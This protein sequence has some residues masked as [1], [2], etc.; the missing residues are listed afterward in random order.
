[1]IEEQINFEF[2]CPVIPADDNNIILAHGSGGLLTQQLISDIFAKEFSNEYLDRMHD[3]AIFTLGGQ[4]FAVS[5]DS[6]V[7]DPVFFPGGNIGDLAVNGTVNDLVMCGAKPMFLSAAFIIEEGFSISDLRKIVSSMY[8]AAE[9][10]G[11]KIITGDTKVVQ[12][13]KGDKIFINT[14]GIGILN[15]DLYIS[16]S[17]AKP[18]DKIILSGT[19]ADHAICILAAREKLDFITNIFSDTASLS[20]IV[21]KIFSVTKNIH[22]LRDPTRGGIASIL[23]EIAQSSGVDIQIYED[24]IRIKEEINA[25]CEILGFD[26]LY[27]ANEG[28]FICIL[29]EENADDVLAVLRDDPLGKDAE[30]IG[31]VLCHSDGKVIL[32]TISGI[33]RFLDLMAGD[34]LPRIC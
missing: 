23:I 2:G 3:G 7:V 20:S 9:I 26:P 1:M 16:P 4:N 11:V 12:K 32:K 14:T 31:E 17:S 13:G 21:E 33:G 15:A 27:L 25:A 24:R 5:T 6:F 22:V 8:A 18:G 28:K 30:I 19:I 10:S 34:Q 29:P